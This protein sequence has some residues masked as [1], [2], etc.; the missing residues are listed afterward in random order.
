[1]PINHT[2]IFNLNKTTFVPNRA[3][4]FFSAKLITILFI[5]VAQIAISNVKVTTNCFKRCRKEY[6]NVQIK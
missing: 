1:M 2:F 6:Y 4:T 3:F 5:K